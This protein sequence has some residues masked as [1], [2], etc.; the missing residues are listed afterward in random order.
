MSTHLDSELLQRLGAGER[1][2]GD[3]ARDAHLSACPACRDQV[4]SWRRLCDGLGA[5]EAPDPGADFAAS[6]LAR[7][8]EAP[9]ALAAPAPALKP[10]ALGIV[11]AG[12]AA[13]LLAFFG[14]DLLADL[15]ALVGRGIGSLGAALVAALAVLDGLVAALPQGTGAGLLIG[16]AL[17]F[18]ALARV[19]LRF[20]PLPSFEENTP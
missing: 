6:V 20:A 8:D 14:T 17:F 3:A 18:A 9:A 19:L 15:P 11:A 2:P 5:L 13:G 16:E 1:L 12:L 4:E 7:L 10:W